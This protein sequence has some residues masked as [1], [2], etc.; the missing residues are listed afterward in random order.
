[1]LKALPFI[2]GRA[3]DERDDTAFWL[4]EER[5]VLVDCYEGDEPADEATV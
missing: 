1:V 3:D 2:D 4:G 5:Y